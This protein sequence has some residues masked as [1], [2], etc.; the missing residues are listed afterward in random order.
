MIGEFGVELTFA[1][2]LM[3]E[4]VFVYLIYKVLRMMI[5]R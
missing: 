4:V 2:I 5:K 1:I 3:L